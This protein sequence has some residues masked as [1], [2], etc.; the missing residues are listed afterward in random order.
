MRS[1]FKPC[2]ATFFSILP[3][4]AHVTDKFRAGRSFVRLGAHLCSNACYNKWLQRCH[5]TDKRFLFVRLAFSLGNLD[6]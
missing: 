5:Q 3:D 6:L 1:F 2:I 4:V